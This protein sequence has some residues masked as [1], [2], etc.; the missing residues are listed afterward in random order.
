V[1]GPPEDR[2]DA[3]QRRHLALVH[4]HAPA[5]ALVRTVE[6]GLALPTFEVAWTFP[7]AVPPG[8]GVP[9]HAVLACL[10][11]TED[12]ATPAPGRT[13][14][15]LWVEAVPGRPGDADAWW[16]ADDRPPSGLPDALLPALRAAVGGAR[17]DGDPAPPAFA[18]R[19]ATAALA[20]ALAG[21]ARADEV[22]SLLH[23]GGPRALRQRRA[24]SLS[25][26]WS[27][28]TVYLKTVPPMWAAEGA[29]TAWLA[30]LAPTRVPAVV[31]LGRAEHPSGALPWF[32]QQ[33]VPAA[34]LG[35]RDDARG[36]CAAAMGALVARVRGELEVGAALGLDDRSPRSVAAA[37]AEVW[38]SPEL[39][40]L[41]VAERASLPELDARLRTRLAALDAAG[42]PPVL[43]HGDLH[44]GNVLGGAGGTAGDVVIDWTDAAV[45]W[46]GADLLTVLGLEARLDDDVAQQVVDSYAE[47]AGPALGPRGADAVRLGLRAAPA[48]H[49][50]SYARIEANLPL[51]QRWQLAGSVRCLVRRMLRDEGLG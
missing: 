38:A 1:S 29:V 11:E 10:A 30:Q 41:E 37:L 12:E 7:S 6:G 43:V 13:D 49:A 40:S 9:P 17:D 46:P 33:A 19:G 42:L 23:P 24:W 21:D 3:R 32:V 27:N 34:D 22:V 45:G 47:A 31:A 44:G 50:L 5:V 35:G 18:V 2:P 4:P 28:E 51:S 48:Y 26:V 39:G 14:R 16:S 36:R 20:A 15:L 8:D 25:S